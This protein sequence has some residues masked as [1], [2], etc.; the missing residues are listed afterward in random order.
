MC[1]RDR[2]NAEEKEIDIFFAK[3]FII[4]QLIDEIF[5]A[6]YGTKWAFEGTT[7]IPGE[8]EIAC[9]YFVSTVLRDAGF[10]LDRFKFGKMGP[11]DL[12]RSLSKKEDI[13]IITREEIEDIINTEPLPRNGL[14]YFIMK[15]KVEGII[16]EFDEELIQK[17][18]IKVICNELKSRGE[19][20]YLFGLIDR[21]LGHVGFI[22][23]DEEQIRLVH[24][25]YSSPKYVISEKLESS[26]EIHGYPV[27]IIGKL[28][29]D[30]MIEKW[31]LNREI[32]E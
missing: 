11:E 20:I 28:F 16:F 29:S 19:G 7:E 24:S 25:S 12:V 13:I 18:R 31:I 32:S 1:I 14:F 27:I 10:K 26:N 2:S 9:G 4:S 22:V 23:N 5:P 3:K 8:G 21:T 15:K 17:K 6:W 30:E